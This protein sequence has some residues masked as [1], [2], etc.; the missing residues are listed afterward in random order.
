MLRVSTPGQSGERGRVTLRNSRCSVAVTSRSRKDPL[1]QKEHPCRSFGRCFSMPRGTCRQ[2]VQG[3]TSDEDGRAYLYSGRGG[4]ASVSC[5][6]VG[7]CFSGLAR[8]LGGLLFT[9]ATSQ[10]PKGDERCTFFRPWRQFFKAADALEAER[11]W[12]VAT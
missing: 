5:A 2:L 11:W 4:T 9:K 6:V 8:Q 10:A 7:D 1:V 12:V 3:W